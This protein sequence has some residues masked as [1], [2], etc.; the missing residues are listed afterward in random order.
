MGADGIENRPLGD[1]ERPLD[2][3]SSFLAAN[4]RLVLFQ[5]AF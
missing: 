1:A 2:H 3:F 4:A 5:K